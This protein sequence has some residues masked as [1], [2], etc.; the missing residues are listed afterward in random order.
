MVASQVYTHDPSRETYQ[1]RLEG[2]L[3]VNA[4]S[5]TRLST[6]KQKCCEISRSFLFF[7]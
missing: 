7:E 1:Q 5:D 6:I 2:L 3:Q 4:S